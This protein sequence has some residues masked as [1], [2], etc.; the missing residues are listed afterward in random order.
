MRKMRPLWPSE[1]SALLKTLCLL[2]SLRHSAEA[3][4]TVQV[5]VAVYML[6]YFCVLSGFL[7]KKK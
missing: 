6:H 7:S 3:G 1:G 4:M 5:L 2:C